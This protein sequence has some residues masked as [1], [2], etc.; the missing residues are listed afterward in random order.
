MIRFKPMTEQAE[1]LW[2]KERTHVI[3]CEDTQGI[4]A[5]DERGI[6]AMGVFDTWTVDSCCVHLCVDNPI[7]IRRGLLHEIGHYAYN[8]CGRT[9][10]FGLVPSNNE[11]ALKLDRHIGFTEV[12]RVPDGVRKGV[13]VVIMRLDKEDCRWI[14]QPAKEEAA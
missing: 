5:F 3:W 4:V 9:H 1:W 2:F 12:T 14:E 6:Q 11:K 13:D 10:L 7:A 8:V